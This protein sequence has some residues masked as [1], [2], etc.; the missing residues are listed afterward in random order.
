MDIMQ[1]LN[2]N[3]NQFKRNIYILKILLLS[4]FDEENFKKLLFV[5]KINDTLEDKANLYLKTNNSSDYN[6]LC[7]DYST[8]E[9]MLAELK[10]DV[11][12][13]FRISSVLILDNMKLDD[14]VIFYN[15]FINIMVKYKNIVEASNDIFYH[16]G[17]EISIFIDKLIKYINSHDIDNKNL[18]PL[19]YLS[20]H[21][22]I[23]TLSL[24]EWISLFKN[25]NT[26]MKYV[27]KYT[28][29]EIES[30][31]KEFEILNV[32]YYIILTGG[33]N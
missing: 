30:L 4:K 7:N 22:V 11:M 3:K 29:K 18:I 24:Q 26:T 14:I 13:N 27:N 2:K 16:S 9:S 12:E 10:E 1:L 17:K 31:K 15:H 25:I 8:V 21:Q 23:V 20:N 19:A 33:N 5:E 6:I 28:D 32:Y